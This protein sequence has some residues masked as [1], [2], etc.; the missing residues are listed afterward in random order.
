MAHYRVAAHCQLPGCEERPVNFWKRKPP[1]LHK[2]DHLWATSV[3]HPSG[4]IIGGKEQCEC[5]DVKYWA[6]DKAI[7]A[8]L[9]KQYEREHPPLGVLF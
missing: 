1:H 2:F 9:D 7:V 6:V 5:G 4:L 8:S 3:H